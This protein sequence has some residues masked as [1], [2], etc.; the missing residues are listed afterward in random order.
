[1]SEYTSVSDTIAH[2]NLHYDGYSPRTGQVS[3]SC[4][5]QIFLDLGM[6]YELM[7]FVYNTHTGQVRLGYDHGLVILRTW[8]HFPVN[9]I[10][11]L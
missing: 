4:L 9:S 11:T 5:Q 10:K 8:V 7:Q 6:C 2:S 1:M 3:V